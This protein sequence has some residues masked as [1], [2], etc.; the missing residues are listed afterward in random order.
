M[1]LLST[2]TPQQVDAAE[3]LWTFAARDFK[4]AP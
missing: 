1:T 3:R 2:A 4:I